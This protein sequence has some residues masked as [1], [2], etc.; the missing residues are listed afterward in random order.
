MGA[1]PGKLIAGEGDD[2][3]LLGQFVEKKLPPIDRTRPSLGEL[4]AGWEFRLPTEAWEYACRAGTTTA[5]SFGDS[6]TSTQAN[7]GKAY[8]GS[9]RGTGHGGGQVGSYPANPW[10]LHDMHGNGLSGAAIGITRGFPAESIP[11][12]GMHPDHQIGMAPIRVIAAERG[13]TPAVA[14]PRCVCDEPPR[15][16]DSHWLPAWCQ[17]RSGE[18]LGSQVKRRSLTGLKRR[19]GL[20]NSINPPWLCDRQRDAQV[21]NRKS[22]I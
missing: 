17:N 22:Q 6:L 4:P 19:T 10:G 11:I 2:F 15:R 12:C 21:T 16:S 8:N 5:F 7:I 1:I 18:G 14:A 3:R 20:I 13:W 9:R